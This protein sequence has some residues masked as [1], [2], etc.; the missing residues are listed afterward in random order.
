MWEQLSNLG[1]KK[2]SS[3]SKQLL[4]WKLNLERKEVDAQHNCMLKLGLDHLFNDQLIR[5]PIRS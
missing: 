2:K 5:G 1:G 4:S 3:Y